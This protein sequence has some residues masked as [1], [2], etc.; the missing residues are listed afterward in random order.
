M[1]KK[2][3]QTRSEMKELEE[4]LKQEHEKSSEYLNRLMYLQAD[5]ENYQ[6]QMEKEMRD[7]VQLGKEKI[8]L[9]LLTVID[10]LELALRS[11]RETENKE[12]LLEGVEMTLK[13]MYVTLAHEGLAKIDTVGKSFDPK[14]HE[15]VMKMP[16]NEHNEGV[17]VEEVR[18]G[19]MLKGKVIRM[20]MVKIATKTG[21]S[22]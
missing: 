18:K 3:T 22:S 9:D 1:K 2:P 20:S 11:G 6:K 15:V 16:T 5:F 4:K 7:M 8:I 13:K 14:M 19:F 17:I 10:E 21:V 12:A